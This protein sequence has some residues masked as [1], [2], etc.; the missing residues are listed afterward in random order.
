MVTHHLYFLYLFLKF[1]VLGLVFGILGAR[2]DAL[3]VIF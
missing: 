1:P 3:C 2:R